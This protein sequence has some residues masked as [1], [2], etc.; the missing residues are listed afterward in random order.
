VDFGA[1]SAD[2]S[3][4]GRAHLIDRA[5]KNH[6]QAKLDTVMGFECIASDDPRLKGK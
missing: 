6:D 5:K 3:A 1:L 4:A 2:L